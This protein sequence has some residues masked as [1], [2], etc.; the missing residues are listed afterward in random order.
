LSGRPRLAA[1]LNL[2]NGKDRPL[3]HPREG[4]FN[5]IHGRRGVPFVQ[6][7]DVIGALDPDGQRQAIPDAA[8]TVRMPSQ[9]TP[10]VPQGPA[11]GQM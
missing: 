10:L 1:D 9:A 8:D 2:P 3:D 6:Q 4:R 5:G 7:R 11:G